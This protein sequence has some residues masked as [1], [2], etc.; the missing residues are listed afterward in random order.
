MTT[1]ALIL[2]SIAL[3]FVIGFLLGDRRAVRQCN[4]ILD[5]H[6]REL[7]LSIRE[8]RPLPADADDEPTRPTVH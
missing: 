3:A 8:E 4:G 1:L 2:A 6:W 7:M 5:D